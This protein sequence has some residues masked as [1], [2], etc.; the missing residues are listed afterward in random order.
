MFCLLFAPD[1]QVI[2]GV[3]T[4]PG[5]P[6]ADLLNRYANVCRKHL[7]I[8]AKLSGR[9]TSLAAGIEELSTSLLKEAAA[10]RDDVCSDFFWLPT[11]L[12]F[13]DSCGLLSMIYMMLLDSLVPVR[14]GKSSPYCGWVGSLLEDDNPCWN[15]GISVATMLDF[16]LRYN[17][18]G[19]Y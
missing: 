3:L 8:S 5:P 2:V 18:W 9:R 7:Q 6:E 1:L 10:L 11:E 14:A 12:R 19:K 15:T 17:I 16:R 13:R 4:S